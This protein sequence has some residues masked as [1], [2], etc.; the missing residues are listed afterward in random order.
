MIQGL[1]I[2]LATLA[3]SAG[4]FMGTAQAQSAPAP[5]A[6]PASTLSWMVYY[7]KGLSP[8]DL[9][10]YALVILDADTD[11]KV[12][13]LANRDKQVFG[14]LSIGEI[15]THR[16]QF[17]QFKDSGILLQENAFW[18]GSYMV[19]MRDPRWIKHLIEERIPALLHRG[20][21]GIFL[22]TLDNAGELERIDN[23][24]YKGMVDAAA[25]VVSAIR[26]HYPQVPIIQNRGYEIL[27][28]TAGIVNYVM[29]ESLMA[30]HNFEKKSYY[31]VPQELLDIQ[32]T[33]LAKALEQNPKLQILSLD[34]WS[35][36]DADSIKSIYASQRERGFHPYV[37]TVELDI[38][39]REPR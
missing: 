2:L 22:D 31:M 23:E 25:R 36:D 27:P 17:A 3:M 4:L 14:Y 9:D 21:N 33:L 10:P 15:G 6:Q 29:A 5:S 24:K 39:V 38:I 28:Q 7:H 8:N 32:L 34:Y 1:T 37:A 18:P 20:F 11:I 13:E 12:H 19:D 35:P 26:M 16:R 30:D